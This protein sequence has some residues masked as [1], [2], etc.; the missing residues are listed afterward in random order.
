MYDFDI[1]RGKGEL[2]VNADALSRYPRCQQCEL[3][4][5]NPKMKRN[6]K[7]LDVYYNSDEKNIED[8][9]DVFISVLKNQGVPISKDGAISGGRESASLWRSRRELIVLEKDTL[10]IRREGE[11]LVIPRIN[12]RERIILDIHSQF[13]HLGVQ[14]T[15]SILKEYY[16]W[17]GMDVDIALA[18][19]E[20]SLFQRYK[21]NQNPKAKESGSLSAFIPFDIL[22]IDVAGPL[23]TTRRGN[24][25][26][27]G[28]ID[29]FSKY[30]VLIPLK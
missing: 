1:E 9:I 14:G 17:F 5:E 21:H 25:Y 16:F 6:T 4:H 30:P 26:I 8:P 12:D 3:L 2:H 11:T 7:I 10:G 27:L 13:G 23:K 28:M 18:I 24:S 19:G 29:H 20:C 22:A 15:K